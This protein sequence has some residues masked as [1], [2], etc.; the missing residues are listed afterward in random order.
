MPVRKIPRN[1]RSVTG[2]FPSIKNG[3]GV[4]YES[5]LERDFF[6]NLEFLD[7]VSSYEEQPFEVPHKKGNKTAPPFYPDC[8]ITYKPEIYKRPLLADIKDTEY[9]KKNKDDFE[10]RTTIL[11]QFAEDL[12][13][14]YDVFTEK[15]IRGERLDNIK[16]LYKYAPIP[17]GLDEVI[18]L[19]KN[20]NK[21]C[22]GPVTV[23]E[24]L[25]FLTPDQN[26]QLMIL[27][28]IWHLI[29]AKKIRTDMEKKITMKTIL[30]V[31]DSW[32]GK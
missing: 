7:D 26:R 15:N 11:L 14:D 6:N 29:W 10:I 9:I 12:F 18:C 13:I 21:T 2:F 32:I 23:N 25:R 16:M 5:P 8:L 22:H 3:R 28:V 4:A 31:D 1:Y 24:L 30:V 17:K 19:L 20:S 27:P